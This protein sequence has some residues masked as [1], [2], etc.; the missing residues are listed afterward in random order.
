M[1]KLA[2]ILMLLYCALA[3]L[4][5]VGD[6]D[7]F[8]DEIPQA[9]QEL[10]ALDDPDGEYLDCLLI[11]GTPKGDYCWLLSS[12]YIV[13]YRQENGVW[14]R[15]SQCDPI[16]QENASALYFRRHEAGKAEG[17]Q[18]EAGLIYANE[19]GFDIVRGDASSPA[20][21][22]ILQYQWDGEYFALVGWQ[23]GKSGQFAIWQD[24]QWAF[25]D[26]LTGR[27]LGEARV[28]SLNQ[29]GVLAWFSYLPDTLAQ[30]QGMEAITQASV[31]SL[32]PGWTLADYDAYNMGHGADVSYY[33]IDGNGLTIRRETFTSAAGGVASRMDTMPVP[34]SDELLNR[35]Q[36]EPFD[37]LI[38]TS[39]W[40]ETFLVDNALDESAMPIT[41]TVLQSD[42]QS[43]GLLLLTEMDNG[44]RFLVWITSKADGGY[45]FQSSGLMPKDAY[46]DLFHAGDGVIELEWN[47]QN[48]QCG[49]ALAADGIW[50]LSWV[51]TGETNYALNYC[52]VTGEVASPAIAVTTVG[53]HPWHDLFCIDVASLPAALPV[54]QLD[55]TGWAVVNNP[56]PA[57]R[58]HL[59]KEPDRASESLGKFYNRTPVQALSQQGEWTRVRI[60][61]DG[62]LE[63]WM[64]TA[65]LAFGQ[66]MDGV[67][68]ASPIKTLQ[69]EH[70]GCELFAS[71]DGKETTGV[72]MD[73][74]GDCWI[75]GV[76]GDEWYILLNTQGS[77]GYLP[78]SWMWDGNG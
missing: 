22:D 64:L 35:L 21:L 9:V 76:I 52:G 65:Y 43:H 56:D 66:A 54:S 49:A 69:E 2:A 63:G 28:P 39:G 71:P 37:T 59:R 20:E 58:L 73:S 46:L 16:E 18:G 61:L 30:A 13:G 78:Q 4:C 23:K 15:D 32:F 24:E 41:G 19:W 67:A 27:R 42:L 7:H 44:E 14:Q 47:G 1:K 29:D 25:C 70:Q 62:R 26:S 11:K 34:L 57:D 51:M 3:P 36:S 5:A 6:A 60:G 33:R 55:R 77:T 74:G 75:A 45:V 38:D 17:A 72:V 31:Q 10:A 68:C 8:C 12:W 53:T 50:R 48:R 40:G